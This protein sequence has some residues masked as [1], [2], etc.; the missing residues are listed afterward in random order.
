MKLAGSSNEATIRNL[1]PED[2]GEVAR[3]HRCAFPRSVIT[4]LGEEATKRYYDWL[5]T[6]PHDCTA[7][8]IIIGGRLRGY[9]FA[10]KFRGAL[11]GYLQRN[12]VYLSIRVLLT[13][14]VMASEE[15]REKVRAGARIVLW[16][17]SNDKG[18]ACLPRLNSCGLLS[19]AV[20]PALQGRGLGLQLLQ[21]CEAYA[22]EKGFEAMHLTVKVDNIPAMHLYLRARWLKVVE[23]S[24][25]RGRMEKDLR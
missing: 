25:W 7:R 9:F 16:R 19:I 5:L 23:N 10:G 14:Q 6:G 1:T 12:R 22:R 4:Q 2:L 3:I 8:G 13:P 21:D 20:D 17:R 11:S 15:M 18:P 24:E